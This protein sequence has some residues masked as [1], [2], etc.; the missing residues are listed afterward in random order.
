M[1]QKGIESGVK[2]FPVEDDVDRYLVNFCQFLPTNAGGN[3]WLNLKRFL[4]E[5]VIINYH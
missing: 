4:A 5:N 1:S 3:I 2:R